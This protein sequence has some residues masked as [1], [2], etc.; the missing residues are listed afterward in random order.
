[1]KKVIPLGAH[2][3]VTTMMK[4]TKMIW[5]MDLGLE[6]ADKTQ[7]RRQVDIL[8]ISQDPGMRHQKMSRK[9]AMSRAMEGTV[10]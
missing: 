10:M 2:I 4:T 9:E 5:E 7:D 1:M 3:L 6:A 8:R